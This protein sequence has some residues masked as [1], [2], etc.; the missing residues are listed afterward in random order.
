VIDDGH[1]DDDD[2]DDDVEE[3]GDAPGREEERRNCRPVC[4][5]SRISISAICRKLSTNNPSTAATL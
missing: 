1:D 3:V 2:E 5:T 4:L